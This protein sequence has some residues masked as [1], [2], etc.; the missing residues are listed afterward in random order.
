MAYRPGSTTPFFRTP[1]QKIPSRLHAVVAKQKK[2]I[3][4]RHRVRRGRTG[5]PPPPASSQQYRTGTCNFQC[6]PRV[7]VPCLL[8]STPFS[9]AP[10]RSAP[11]LLDPKPTQPNPKGRDPNSTQ[12]NPTQTNLSII[13]SSHDIYSNQK[14]LVYTR[15]Y[16]AASFTIQETTSRRP[17]SPPVRPPSAPL[18]PSPLLLLHSPPVQP[19][20][21]TPPRG[22]TRSPEK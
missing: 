3:A 10:L 20:F 9:L 15:Q 22:W 11:P 6:E 13:S 17:S 12:P 4:P 18:Q 19:G 21:G 5:T 16:I 2:W 8:P 7:G 1:P 14:R